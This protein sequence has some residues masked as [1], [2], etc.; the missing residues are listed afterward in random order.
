MNVENIKTLFTYLTALV[1]I[2]GSLAIIYLTR[3][4]A[5][6]Q[7]IR[8]LLAGFVGAA[9]QFL[10]S[11]RVAASAAANATPTTVYA[12]PP[13]TV[14]VS[15]GADAVQVDDGGAPAGPPAG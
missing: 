11:E 7:E 8:L 3:A 4:E 13:S 6:G 9:T 15:G 12:S 5:N 1:L 14:N 2:V 10:F